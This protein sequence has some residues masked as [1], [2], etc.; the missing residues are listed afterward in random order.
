MAFNSFSYFLFLP[1]V[2]IIYYFTKDSCRWL[3]LLAAS[4]VF[5]AFLKVP[6]LI[7]ILLLITTI[8]YCTGIGIE[9]SNIPKTKCYLLWGGIAA[10]VMTLV[11]L[12]YLPFLTQNLNILIR[13]IASLIMSFQDKPTITYL[14]LN[15]IN[16]AIISIGASYYIFQAISYLV[17]IYLGIEKAERNFGYFALYMSFFPK[18]L[19]G[20]IERAADL[21]PQLK[22]PYTFSYDTVRAGM[23]LFVW[24]L[25]KKMVIA[26]RLALL[27][28]PVFNNVHAYVGFP[29][30]LA[31]YYYALQIYFDFSGYTDMAIGTAGIFNIT[32]TRNFN[33]PYFAT[34]IADFWRR[35]HISFS[36][37]ILDYIFKPLQM[38][39]RNWGTWGT[40]T[41]LLV[42]FLISG[43]WHGANWGFIVWGLLHGLYLA[44]S[45]F[46][47]PIQKKI[48]KSLGI[49]SRSGMYKTWQVFFTFN[50]VC[51]AWIFFRA[52]TISDA[53]YIVGNMANSFSNVLSISYLENNI[54]FGKDIYEFYRLAAVFSLFMIFSNYINTITEKPAY[55]RWIYYNMISAAILFLGVY[56]DIKFIYN[57][58]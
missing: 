44:C 57:R 47:K 39:C 15:H 56:D 24:G 21:L 46:Y 22:K 37:W 48:H 41:A 31:T 11:L 25:F 53:L 16:T 38:S 9:R 17:D 3:V 35:W 20:P 23:L 26:D 40:A 36:R 51:F 5:Y 13:S 27:V 10:N 19:Q 7:P 43:V 50:L 52:N 1:A 6:H 58:F 34:S 2:F 29:L 18:L 12:K 54:V 30:L 33:K 45:V 8:T 4:I 14:V 32:L 42:T 28:D 55:V 49:S